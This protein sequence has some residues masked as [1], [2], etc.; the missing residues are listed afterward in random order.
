MIFIR[1]II[2]W[3][4]YVLPKEGIFPNLS[5][6]PVHMNQFRRKMNSQINFIFFITFLYSLNYL[7]NV[8][9]YCPF[10]QWSAYLTFYE[11]L[12]ILWWLFECFGGAR[13]CRKACV[14][15]KGHMFK[16]RC[17][18]GCYQYHFPCT[19]VNDSI[20]LCIRLLSLMT[21]Y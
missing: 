16:P 2:C 7:K 17:T 8:F 9:N 15:Q 11:H 19:H 4:N 5:W 6:T 12:Q 18:Q 20:H 13:F 10:Y 3:I 1:F 14:V 21:V